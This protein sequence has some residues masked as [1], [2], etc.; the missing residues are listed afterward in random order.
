[1]GSAGRE[2]FGGTIDA[3]KKTGR[4]FMC[5]LMCRTYEMSKKLFEDFTNSKGSHGVYNAKHS[6]LYKSM[7]YTKKAIFL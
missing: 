5:N 2:F 3:E 7:R 1:M 4:H 6:E